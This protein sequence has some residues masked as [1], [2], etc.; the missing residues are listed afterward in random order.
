[1]IANSK[2]DQNAGTGVY[3]DFGTASITDSSI[4]NNASC[5]IQTA[6]G[7]TLIMSGS[8]VS[9]NSADAGGGLYNSDGCVSVVSDT[10]IY[11]NTAATMGGGVFNAGTLLLQAGSV[12]HNKFDL[13]ERDSRWRRDIQRG[14][15]LG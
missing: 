6:D 13:L 3:I 7:A 5:G 11:G 2:I 12:D 15:G 14:L 1:M 9:D 10:A 8:L 4:E